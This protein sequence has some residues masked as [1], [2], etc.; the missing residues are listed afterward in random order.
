MSKRAKAALASGL[1]VVAMAAV[2]LVQPWEGKENRAYWDRLGSVATVCYGETRGVS[3]GDSFTDEECSEMLYERLERDYHRPLQRCI[4]GFD[5]KP[6]GW[7]AAMLSLAYNVGTGAACKSTAARRAKAGDLAGSCK[8]M[9]W[10]NRAGGRVVQGL[11]NRREGGDAQRIGEYEMCIT[12]VRA[13][14]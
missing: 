6:I 1:G 13:A 2:Y 9:T 4:K 10:F 7:Q 14:Q 12:S 3:M 8:A 11:K 5:D